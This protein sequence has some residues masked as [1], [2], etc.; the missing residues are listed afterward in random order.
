[1]LL[2]ALHLHDIT[3]LLVCAISS[4]LCYGEMGREQMNLWI[5]TVTMEMGLDTMT[6]SPV[7]KVE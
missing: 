5:A 2:G 6:R 7:K 3:C 4:R 1:M